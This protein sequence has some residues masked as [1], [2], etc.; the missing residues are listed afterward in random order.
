MGY[1]KKEEREKRDRSWKDYSNGGDLEL[2][3]KYKEE[4]LRLGRKINGL[5]SKCLG[6]RRELMKDVRLVEMNEMISELEI[7]R[8]EFEIKEGEIVEEMDWDKMK[9]VMLMCIRKD[10]IG[11]YSGKNRRGRVSKG[12]V[13]IILEERKENK[14]RMMCLVGGSVI[15]SVSKNELRSRCLVI[16]D[17]GE[18]NEDG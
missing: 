11:Y 17:D 10:G 14:R 12:E 9:G 3:G 4:K 6:I 8:K 2:K 1:L 18:C 7:E 5:R 15:G 13:I 16:S